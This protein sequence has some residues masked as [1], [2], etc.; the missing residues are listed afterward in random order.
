MEKIKDYKIIIIVGLVIL[1]GAFYWFQIRPTTIK[2]NCSWFTEIIKADP[3]ITKEQAE[4]N[5]IKLNNGECSNSEGRL[6]SFSCYMLEKD[7]K[8]RPPQPEKEVT[9]EA[10][11]NEYDMCLR[12][13][14]L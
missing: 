9:N 14:G 7:T 1:G 4:I 2:R 12:Q 10:T 8:E 6:T 11:K 13:N 3:G 5:K